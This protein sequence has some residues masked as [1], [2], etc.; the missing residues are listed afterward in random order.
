MCSWAS[1]ESVKPATLFLIELDELDAE[2]ELRLS[3][4]FSSEDAPVLIL[5]SQRDPESLTRGA[6]A[7]FLDETRT[8]RRRSAATSCAS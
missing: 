5:A 4:L 3:A 8:L 7:A 6:H 1:V 2:T